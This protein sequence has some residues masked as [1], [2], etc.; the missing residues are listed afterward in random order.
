MIFF[1]KKVC[2]LWKA[3]NTYGIDILNCKS[4]RDFEQKTEVKIFMKVEAEKILKDIIIEIENLLTPQLELMK[5]NQTKID[6]DYQTHIYNIYENAKKEFEE[7]CKYH[8]KKDY[9]VAM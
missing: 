9:E 5:Q 6:N 2:N 3:L 1:Y 7:Q 4:L 8:F